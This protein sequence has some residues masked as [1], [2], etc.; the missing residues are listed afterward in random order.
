MMSDNRFIKWHWG[1]VVV[2]C[3]CTIM[4]L[5][6]AIAKSFGVLVPS[7]VERLDENYATVGLICSLPVTLMYF[8]CPMISLILKRVG[9]RPLALFGGTMSG[10]SLALSGFLPNTVLIGLS[11]ALTGA[12]IACVYMPY[13]LVVND[14]FP[15]HFVVIN[16][17][18]LYG[19]TAG[20]MI[21]PFITERSFEAYG[22]CGTFLILGGL[23]LHLMVCAVAIRKPILK[24]PDESQ[25]DGSRPSHIEG[26]EMLVENGQETQQTWKT[27]EHSKL[28]HKQKN[29]QDFMSDQSPSV[30]SD[31]A[32]STSLS[33]LE[34]VVGERG[35]DQSSAPLFHDDINRPSDLL[36]DVNQNESFFRSFLL[37]EPLF[38]FNLLTI[39]LFSYAYYSWM[40]FLVPHA[41]QL[42]IPESQAVFLSTIAGIG[43]IIG[44]TIFI[45]LVAK[46]VDA[47][48]IY[49]VSGITVT[50]PFLL[51]FIGSKYWI[52]AGLAFLQGLC[53]FAEDAIFFTV[54]KNTLF[55]PDHLSLAIALVSFFFGLGGSSAGFITG[56][57][58]DLTQS[59]TK[60][61][62]IIG[63]VLV[64]VVLQVII[65]T[66]CIRR[67]TNKSVISE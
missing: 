27:P 63:I 13:M 40:Y 32:R 6:S 42:G 23:T 65:T 60:V 12:G 61:F 54:A 19:H 51:D 10:M 29:V 9:R 47:F 2:I 14:F 3:K 50:L 33:S 8:C 4:F 53:F 62:I 48:H 15:D 28:D 45:V 7:M 31:I 20:T 55:N 52:R 64:T 49:I 59:F 17:I 5:D 1:Y 36:P 43:G 25:R 18:S 38:L 57:L 56:S 16:T 30:T 67:R 11:M 41:K 34:E 46:G 44:R 37:K 39:Y 22:Y 58:F 66:V 24:N 26:D 21:L 35:T